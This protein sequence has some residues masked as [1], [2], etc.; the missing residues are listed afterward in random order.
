MKQLYVLW[1]LWLISWSAVGQNKPFRG[2]WYAGTDVGIFSNKTRMVVGELS[3]YSAGG[4]GAMLLYGLKVGRSLNPYLAFE[5]GVYAQPLNLVYQYQTNR[6]TGFAPL[7]FMMFPMRIHY[8]LQVLNEELEA[9]IGG[10]LQ[11]IWTRNQLAAQSFGG[12][13]TTPS[14]ARSDSLIYNGSVDVLR[15][16]S[17]NAEISL[18][19][20][21]ALS[22]RWTVNVYGRQV[23]G[24][25]NVAQVD[26]N[27]RQNQEPVQSAEFV[28]RGSG[29]NLGLGIKYN[30]RK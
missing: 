17:L 4:S 11:Y 22:R 8:R 13:I 6:A 16:S 27:I 26:V 29:F 25:V 15:N 19:I 1:G 28:S 9:Q 10:G 18:G 12:S 7:H 14:H 20:N 21:W 23:L 24:L 30:L 3:K 2:H 5:T